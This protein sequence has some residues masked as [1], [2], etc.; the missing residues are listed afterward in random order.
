MLSYECEDGRVEG[1]ELR[2]DH[3]ERGEFRLGLESDAARLGCCRLHQLSNG[4]EE[5]ANLPIV[6]ANSPLKLLQLHRHLL[7]ARRKLPQLHKC[8]HDCNIHVNCPF[9]AENTG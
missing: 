3:D 2:T 7:M 8:S 5:G 1:S 9:A 6:S 4:F